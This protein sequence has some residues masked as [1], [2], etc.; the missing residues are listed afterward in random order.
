MHTH[1]RAHTYAYTHIYIHSTA[2]V[3]QVTQDPAKKVASVRT[4][5]LK[6][7]KDLNLDEVV[8]A[9]TVVRLA[10]CLLLPPS[11]THRDNARPRSRMYRL[12]TTQ[13]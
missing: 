1:I 5:I 11:C 10:S 12:I 9:D 7:A 2:G 4:F 6:L 8:M 3:W 13:G